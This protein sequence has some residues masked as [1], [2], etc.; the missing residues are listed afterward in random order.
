MTKSRK[1][2]AKASS[3]ELEILMGGK[4]MNCVASAQ[5]KQPNTASINRCEIVHMIAHLGSEIADN[6]LTVI[7]Q[8]S[9][10]ST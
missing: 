5:C 9:T 1:I 3:K 7:V 4:A 10:L 8:P 2:D 6:N